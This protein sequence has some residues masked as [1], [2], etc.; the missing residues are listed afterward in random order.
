MRLLLLRKFKK[1]SD[2]AW[3]NVLKLETHVEE[4]VEVGGE[5][6]NMIKVMA[7]GAEAYSATELEE[8]EVLKIYCRVNSSSSR[9]GP[10]ADRFPAPH[11]YLHDYTTYLF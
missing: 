4:L 2:E 6:G 7:K 11:Q 10:Y 5:K 1:L 8:E 3:E 9:S